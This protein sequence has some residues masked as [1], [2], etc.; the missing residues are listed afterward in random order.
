M[1]MLGDSHIHPMRYLSLCAVLALF[2]NPALRADDKKPAAKAAP[3]KAAPAKATPAKPGAAAGAHGPTTPVILQLLRPVVPQ[4]QPAR[5]QE[6]AQ[7]A[8]LLDV[9]A[10]LEPLQDAAEL[11]VLLQATA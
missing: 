2:V 4:P 5:P 7:L 11:P 1:S 8:E 9:A 6:R 3:A 10:R